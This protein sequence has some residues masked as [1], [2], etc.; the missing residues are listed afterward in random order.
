MTY[1]KFKL[2]LEPHFW[3]P[4]DYNSKTSTFFFFQKLCGYFNDIEGLRYPFTYVGKF[5]SFSL[6]E[7]ASSKIFIRPQ[8]LQ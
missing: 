1:N 2:F 7:K 4:R 5:Y 8:I 3:S 6:E